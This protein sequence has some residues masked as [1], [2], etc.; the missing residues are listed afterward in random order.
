MLKDHRKLILR[1][2]IF[3]LMISVGYLM[4][5]QRKHFI[6][7]P[8]RY[9]YQLMDKD[10]KSFMVSLEEYQRKNRQGFCWRDQKYYTRDELKQKAMLSFVEDVLLTR[11][12]FY[13]NGEVINEGERPSGDYLVK[14]CKKRLPKLSPLASAEEIYKSGNSRSNQ[15]RSGCL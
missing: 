7:K 4:Y 10:P 1:I 9:W 3:V 6:Q 2:V 5:C 8:Y 13:K 14:L 12:N 15:I 11:L